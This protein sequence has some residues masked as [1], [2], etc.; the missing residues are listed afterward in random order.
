MY[1]TNTDPLRGKTHC[2]GNFGRSGVFMAS[3]SSKRTTTVGTK[4][5]VG[6]SKNE[7]I[8]QAA[9]RL[10][11]ETLYHNLEFN[12]RNSVLSQLKM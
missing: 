6:L 3:L 5:V 11:K 7:V 10:E 9:P 8:W 1:I 12:N 4:V 2:L